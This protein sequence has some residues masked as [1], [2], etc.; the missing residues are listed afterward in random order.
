M[1]ARCP[2]YRLVLESYR[3]E[4]TYQARPHVLL[5]P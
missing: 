3:S 4:I 5:D 1:I 2:V